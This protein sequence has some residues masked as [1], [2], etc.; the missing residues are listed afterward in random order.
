MSRQTPR[1]VAVI[2][3]GTIA[4]GWIA[5]FA[6]AGRDVRVSST[7][8]DAREHLDAALPAYAASLPGGAREPREILARVRVVPEV[9]D[10]VDGVEAVQENAPEDL[11]LKQ[12]LF[13]RVAEAA[14]PEALLLSSTSTLPPAALGALLDTPERVVVGHPFNPPHI[15]P[16]VEVVP[17]PDA[18]AALVARATAFYTELG[19]SPVVLRRALPGFVA[20]R[21]QTALLR[22]AIHL[23]REGVVTV[24]EL[25]TVVTSSIGQR[26][27]AVGPFE[28]F[29]LG[30]GP[31]GLRHWFAHLGA[32]LERGW[33]SLGSPPADEETVGTILAQAE[34]GFGRRPYAELAA[35]RD[36]R[37]NAVIA[38]LAESAA[39]EGRRA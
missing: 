4:L 22:E 37:Q 23:V 17:A 10:A 9:G 12:K 13:A 26:W 16:L 21:L 30:G 18:P 8:T 25:D 29:H 39:D 19:K 5:L 3:T 6:A 38:A 34:A 7:R 28:A 32:G 24:G 11:E 33:E 2:G 36:R 20:N 31:G 35:R 14:P 15:V 27:A 1:A